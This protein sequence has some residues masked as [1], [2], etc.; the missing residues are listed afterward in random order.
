MFLSLTSSH[1]PSSDSTGF[2]PPIEPFEYF[3]PVSSA[4]SSSVMYDLP[5]IRRHSPRSTPFT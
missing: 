5:S 2:R 1:V 3:S 4:K